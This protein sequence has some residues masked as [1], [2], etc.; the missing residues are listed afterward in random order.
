MNGASIVRPVPILF[1]VLL[2]LVVVVMK[3]VV[4]KLVFLNFRGA[5]EILDIR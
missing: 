2:K 4:M 3:L 5:E 1:V